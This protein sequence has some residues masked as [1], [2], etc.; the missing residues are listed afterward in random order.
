MM[1]ITRWPRYVDGSSVRWTVP[2]SMEETYGY[3]RQV[4][5]P[6]RLNGGEKAGSIDRVVMWEI[7]LVGGI[8]LSG[9]G[10]LRRE[11]GPSAACPS[12]PRESRTTPSESMVV[13]HLM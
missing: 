4:G 1:P 6:S 13:S 2:Q 5:K 9:G 12:G 7:V 11:R 3:G 10:I 8:F